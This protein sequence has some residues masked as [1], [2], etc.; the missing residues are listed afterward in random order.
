MDGYL[1]HVLFLLVEAIGPTPGEQWL[2]ET[3]GTIG[4]SD[5]PGNSSDGY[6]RSSMNTLLARIE[7][8]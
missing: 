3:S 5:R 7:G 6:I 2:N 1:E 4:G 8:E